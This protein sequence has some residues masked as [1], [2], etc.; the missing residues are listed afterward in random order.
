MEMHKLRCTKGL[1]LIEMSIVLV[2]LGIVLTTL[3]K[4][5]EILRS[6]QI[7]NLVQTQNDLNQAVLMYREKYG[8]LPGDDS[9]ATAHA[10]GSNGNGNSVIEE[11]ERFLVFQH[12]MKAELITGSYDGTNL[13]KSSINTDIQI[14]NINFVLPTLPSPV[15]VGYNYI[16]SD[17]TAATPGIPAVVYLNL[18]YDV[19]QALETALDGPVASGTLT[20]SFLTGS[21]RA[22]KDYTAANGTIPFTYCALYPVSP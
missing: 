19:A 10:G 11:A 22:S 20:S 14:K 16:L 5:G 8:Y 4:G 1:T 21:V 15:P 2:I 12:L 3:V 9:L 6:T 7:K 13:M 18:P 17:G